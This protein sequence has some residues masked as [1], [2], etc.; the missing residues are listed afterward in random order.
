MG[1]ST[2]W[3][4][5]SCLAAAERLG[6]ADDLHDLGGDRVLAGTVH[7]AGE[8]LDQFLG[9]VGGALH[10]P[11][12]DGVLAGRGV[13]QRGVDAGLDVARQQRV[14][15]RAR[16]GLELVVAGCSLAAAGL[17]S[18]PATVA[19]SSGTSGRSTTSCEPVEMKRV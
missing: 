10:R 19:A 1:R 5:A 18:P 9:V 3:T 4:S 14:E 17:P 2:S 11:L 13:Q 16:V 6:A 8:V 7:D 12:L 15:D